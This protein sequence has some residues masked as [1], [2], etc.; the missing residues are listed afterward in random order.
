[1]NNNNNITALFI[2]KKQ[3]YIQHPTNQGRTDIGRMVADCFGT[4]IPGKTDTFFPYQSCNLHVTGMS[5][6]MDTVT[7]GG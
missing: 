5:L 7:N 4:G 6:A 2:D 3:I 1:M